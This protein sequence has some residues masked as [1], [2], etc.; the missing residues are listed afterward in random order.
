MLH[1]INSIVVQIQ[2]K[3]AIFLLPHVVH[4]VRSPILLMCASILLWMLYPP[5]VNYLIDRS[6]PIFVAA[7][8]HTLA[9][10][11]TLA[12]VVFIFAKRKT[13][14]TEHIIRHLRIPA[15]L[16]PAIFSGV[17]ICANHLLLYAAL[18]TSQEFDVIA[19]LIFEAW[20][21]VFFYI[22]ST[23]RKKHRAT[24]ASDYIFSAAAFAGFI[25]LMS[26]NLDITDW[27]LLESP[28]INTILLAGL[29]GLAMAVNCY[30][31]MK[32]MDAWSAISDENQLEL[33]SLDKALLTE[34]GVRSV[35]APIMLTI[36]FLFGDLTNQFDHFDYFLVAFTGIFI[37]ALGSLLY[38]LSVF[39]A[40][41]ASVSVFW[42]FMP[43]G[44]VIILALLQGRLLNQYE[45][46]ASVLIVSANIFLGL[47]YP[48]RSS[49]LMLFSAVCLV[50]IWILFAPSYPIDSYYDLLA[51][52]TIF[53]VL[54]GTFA[55]ERTTTLNRERERLLIEFNESVML[56]ISYPVPDNEKPDGYKTRLNEYITKHLYI[57][58]RVFPNM[59]QMR[60]TQLSIQN[61]KKELFASTQNNTNYRSR[62]L[63]SFQI[64][65]KL[66]TMESDRI[67]PEELVILI[68]LGATNVFFSL[69]FRPESFSTALFALIL[70]TSVIFLIL[71]INERNQ[72]T[73]I[74]HDQS[75]V[76][77]NLLN[78]AA[79]FK[80][81]EISE[82]DDDSLIAINRCLSMKTATS[83]NNGQNYWIFGVFVFLFFGFGYGFLYETLDDVKRDES[84][85]IHSQRDLINAELNIALLDWPSAQVK[86]HI[87]A[88]IINQHTELR[89]Q[90]VKV[91]HEQ[92]FKQMGQQSGSID[93]HPD[94]WVANNTDLIRR[95]VRAFESIKFGNG[96][97]QGKQGLC[98]TNFSG[99]PSLSI[100]DLSTQEIARQFDLSGNGKGDIWVGSKGW[101]SVAI[102]KRRLNAYQLKD[103]YDYHVFDLDLLNQLL[104]R[105]NQNA[106]S[107]LFFCYY[108]DALFSD[109]NV[110]F[111][112]EQQYDN[113]LWTS[114]IKE[115]EGM[116]LAEG[117]SWPQTQIKLGYR[118]QLN[119]RS[120]E[121]LKLLDRFVI[122]NAELVTM[123]SEVEQGK[124]IE[125]LS[126]QWVDN[127][128]DLVLEWLTGFT[129]RD[130][131]Q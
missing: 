81:E 73:Q 4:L 21:I 93:V 25:V 121:L 88:T 107:S 101:A 52:S 54:L 5:V 12:L 128:K 7:I 119:E 127:H 38:D 24:T 76:C 67:P 117:T 37:L 106:Q 56:L 8:S 82:N 102:E 70:A 40:A 87:L 111:I 84:T 19:I 48:L 123:M 9:A 122:D 118:T 18:N 15:L 53:F 61:I 66:V 90:L 57:F 115:N 14:F 34:S 62:L 97:T 6:S 129:L 98:Y 23:L 49:L 16:I 75:L 113:A 50:G 85:P 32:C 42:Y 114:I 10:I 13:S 45:A 63:D 55:L 39:S 91:G 60:E 77:R 131:T 120:P 74:R 51:V 126:Q 27:L 99:L 103:S 96:T 35:A 130:H 95:Y 28:M 11:A 108:P 26:P 58:L 17:L 64:G 110:H 20:P 92:A 100:E 43:V 29:G 116:K 89:A 78:Q 104:H 30:A 79:R 3:G 33:T 86:A 109:S 125:T 44:A 65:Q 105:N 68:L 59:T 46:V 31:R 83:E 22:D 36:L 72:Y 1:T 41:N 2:D 94:I 112:K 80:T 47:R 124:D 69:I 71:V